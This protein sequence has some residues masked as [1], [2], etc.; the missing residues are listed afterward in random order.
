MA[1]RVLDIYVKGFNS[2]LRLDYSV[3]V[4][5]AS[6]INDNIHQLERAFNKDNGIELV[7]FVLSNSERRVL[8]TSFKREQ[9]YNTKANCRGY[10]VFKS[11]KQKELT[12]L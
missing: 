4:A 1:K 5:G 11:T 12:I 9:Y 3:K 2:E 6:E 7:L 10:R 8:I